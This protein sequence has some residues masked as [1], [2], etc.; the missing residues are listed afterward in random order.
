MLSMYTYVIFS[1]KSYF[2]DSVPLSQQHN[3]SPMLYARLNTIEHFEMILFCI[4]LNF[5]PTGDT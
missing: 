3:Y 2:H 4:L 5:E 1:K